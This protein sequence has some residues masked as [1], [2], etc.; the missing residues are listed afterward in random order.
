MS[1]ACTEGPQYIPAEIPYRLEENRYSIHGRCYNDRSYSCMRV[2]PHHLLSRNQYPHHPWLSASGTSYPT[3]LCRSVP[4]ITVSFLSHFFICCPLE[5]FLFCNAHLKNCSFIVFVLT[6][7]YFLT[8]PYNQNASSSVKA[9]TFDYTLI[10][11]YQ[12]FLPHS[13]I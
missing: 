6:R 2:I 3:Y 10:G 7:T 5:T 11:L 9:P 4:T 8:R 1:S 13:E 12:M